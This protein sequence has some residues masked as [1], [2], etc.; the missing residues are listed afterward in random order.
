MPRVPIRSL[1]GE[2][3]GVREPSLI[4]TSLHAENFAVSR[5]KH[6]D[7]SLSLGGCLKMV[8][9]DVYCRVEEQGEVAG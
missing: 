3:V 1:L 8:L 6:K 9:P 4:Q 2:R 7:Y 5:L